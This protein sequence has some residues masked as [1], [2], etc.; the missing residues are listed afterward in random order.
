MSDQ[1]SR[2]DDPSVRASRVAM[3]VPVSAGGIAR[4][5]LRMKLL[6]GFVAVALVPVALITWLDYR[7]T[8]TALMGV[9]YQSLA[10]AA[11][12][13]AMRLDTFMD[14]HLETVA[15]EA[16]SALL[17]QYLA[18]GAARRAELAA[19][20]LAALATFVQRDLS[21]IESHA[22]LDATGRNVLDTEIDNIGQDESAHD[23]FH[24]AIRS[25]RPFA[26]R[27]E[28]AGMQGRFHMSSAIRDARGRV[29]GVLRVRYGAA[30][31]QRLVAE[32]T[33]LLGR[34]SF[35][36][37]LSEDR[38]FLAH[39]LLSR[40]KLSQRL[41]KSVVPLSAA[42]FAELQGDGRLPK[43]PL[44][45]SVVDLPDLARGVSKVGARE[46]H[47]MAVLPAAGNREQAGAV[48]QMITQPWI[49]VFFQPEDEFLAPMVERTRNTVLFATTMLLLVATAAV[50][51]AQLL[52][53]PIV[54]L[55]TVARRVADGDLSAKA[56]VTTRDEIGVLA[57][58]FNTMTDRLRQTL[59][60]LRRSEEN[61]R[62][63]Y[64]HALE[65]IY[66]AGMDGKILSANPAMARLLGY[67]SPAELIAEVGNMQR[68]H[69]H[70]EARA[71][72]TAAVLERDAAFGLEVEFYR[73]DMST[74][75]V[76]INARVVRDEK[77]A[78][79]YT[80]A[81]VTDITQRRRAEERVRYLAQHDALT[82]LPNRGLFRDRIALAI[83]QARRERRSVAVLF[84]DLDHFKHI[85]DSLG[86]QVGD[87]LLRAAARR[88]QRCLR[89]GDSVARLG[90]DEF[91]IGLPRIDS[92]NDAALVAQK[93]IE[94]LARPLV[95]DEHELHVT[96]SIGISLY[97]MDG[98]E[99]DVLMRAADTAM[100]H[101]KE[102]G[103][104]NYQFF[105]SVLNEAAQSRLMIANRLHH[106]LER[107]EFALNYQPQVDLESGR[108]F[109]AEALIRWRQPEF[110]AVT[111]A[112]FVR[113]AE[114]TGVIFQL[115]EWA[116]REA[117]EQL[118]RWR[119]QGFT[120]MRVAVNL[121]PQQFRRAGFPDTAARIL[122]ETGL[123]PQALELELTESTLM[124]QSAE[125]VTILERLA[126][127]GVELA[128][129]DFGTG[130]SS[131]SYLQRFPI[132]TLKI[133][134]SFV[135]G[136]GADPNDTAI[137][138][139]VIAM[140][141]SLH[142]KVVAEGVETFAQAAFLKQQGCPAA[143]GFYYSAPMP[144]EELGRL[145]EKQH[146]YFEVPL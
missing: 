20:T 74:L 48:S 1:R 7:S 138:T 80:E 96:G 131:L 12:Q 3:P 15:S 68:L 65:G 50:V 85:N 73:K 99:V 56:D 53:R 112:E 59:D 121:S 22:L 113:V 55:T 135:S 46:P 25:T 36:V 9:G 122:R 57:R 90:G 49:V 47:F 29:L 63:I 34:G 19:P 2:N 67:A 16:K 128:V 140:A 84:I 66:Q 97:P 86:H 41:F 125:N 4:S 144:A 8:R 109:A 37:L 38:I 124:T 62:A 13:T 27:V 17:A 75:W 146:G 123:P 33:G 132:H 120:D 87:R 42:R 143:Q 24:T 114:E 118:V 21:T 102:K 129:D 134:Q 81:F 5:T 141:N 127:M 69:V 79:L 10:A 89:E 98:E 54:R 83:A 39:G 32:Q 107:G 31:L 94:A 95:V 52:T 18:A 78:P 145:L 72:A 111:P 101:A 45:E 136:I 11:A 91:V 23:Y 119:K 64:T 93:A 43:R 100:Y 6:L 88:L 58:T 35:A 106:A 40:N 108:V 105:T 44:Q 26:A 139:A 103:R 77:G 76:S 117:C 130:Y 71:E 133:D 137:V 30:V 142:L 28:F 61:F 70:R 51:A 110:G 14:G 104:D 60:G 92:S 82:G 126:A 116:L 115:G